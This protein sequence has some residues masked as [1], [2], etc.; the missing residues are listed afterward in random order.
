MERLVV[1]CAGGH[2]KVIVAAA[3]EAGMHVAGVYDDTKEPCE[4]WFR[5]VPILGRV[6]DF[7]GHPDL[8]AIIALGNNQGRSKLALRG[9]EAGVTWVSVIHPW[10][11]IDPSA[12]IGRGVL[13]CAGSVIG[14]DAVV[15]D[16]AIVNTSS[17]VDH[18]DFIGQFAQIAPGA[19]LGG[20]VR[21]GEGALVGIGATVRERIQI[22]AWATVGAGSVVVKD[23]APHT[24]VFG[25]RAIEREHRKS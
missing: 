15:E 11:S 21:V 14:P 13:V 12:S 25:E 19:H 4:N 6:A 7:F 24:M 23:V 5:N 9:D 18:D 20:A 10:V 16:H 17:S 22:G 8:P 1:I 3:L 2:G